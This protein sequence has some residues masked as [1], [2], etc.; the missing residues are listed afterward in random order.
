MVSA[1]AHAEQT[2]GDGGARQPPGARGQGVPRPEG[3]E[4]LL[5]RGHASP[6]ARES[7]GVLGMK[8]TEYVTLML[9]LG[10]PTLPARP[11]A[12]CPFHMWEAACSHPGSEGPP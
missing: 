10:P 2:Q 1:G 6:G 5:A 12:P 8:V 3:A 11:L 4:L 7:P 9:G